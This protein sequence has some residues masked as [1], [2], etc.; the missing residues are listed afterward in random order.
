[1]PTIIAANWSAHVPQGVT[2][3]VIET[4]VGRHK[5]GM[6]RLDKRTHS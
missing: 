6:H 3:D 1:M 5:H 4:N 2:V